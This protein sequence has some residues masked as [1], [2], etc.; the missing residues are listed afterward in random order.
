MAQ[1]CYNPPLCYLNAGFNFRFIEC[2]QL[3]VVWVDQ[4]VG[5]A[6]SIRF[7]H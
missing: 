3:Q 2:Q 1:R 4:P 7:I 5:S 6:S